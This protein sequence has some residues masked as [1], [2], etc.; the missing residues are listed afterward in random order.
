[1]S[2]KVEGELS[3][4]LDA[5]ERAGSCLVPDS[6]RVRVALRRRMGSGGI[7]SPERGMY[8]RVSWWGA[9][10]PDAR[11][12][13]VMRGLQ[14]LHP[15]WVFCGVSAALAHGADVSWDLLGKAHV[16]APRG[17]WTVR[18][19]NIIW[20]E[21]GCGDG[22]EERP[23]ERAGVRVTPLWRTVLDCLRWAGF[24]D[25]IVVADFAARSCPGGKEEL[26]E[27]IRSLA[28]RCRGVGR[29]LE[30]LALAD[31]RAES[32]GESIARAVMIEQGFMLP[33]LQAWV[34]DPLR[35]GRWFRVDFLWVRADGRVI[36]GECDGRRKLLDPAMTG[37]RSP[38]QVLLDQRS[39][40]GLITAYDVSVVRFTYEEAA[41]VRELVRKL[42]LFGVP[43]LGSTLA[44][45]GE[46][47]A[48]DWRSLLRR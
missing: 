7:V 28:G 19:A 11:A 14:A 30:V 2:R 21:V 34:P 35:A 41:G 42:E 37:G 6:E 3:A 18:S 29:A 8:A 33:E 5:A 22:A 44:R 25:G 26:A 17:S 10:R 43:R 20:H 12:L 31:G 48:I 32:G 16:V 4:L 13:A 46:V 24:R 9:L 38:R 39:R 15:G 36:V 45:T 40:E 23:V 47:P 1:M 27:R